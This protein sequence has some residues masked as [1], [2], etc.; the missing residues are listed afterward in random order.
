MRAVEVDVVA[1]ARK[2]AN[3]PVAVA[4]LP[5]I[6]LIERRV[7]A[8][9]VEPLAQRRTAAAGR[10]A[11]T[12]QVAEPSASSHVTSVR[13]FGGVGSTVG[14]HAQVP[15]S[16]TTS[17][18]LAGEQQRVARLQV[19]RGALQLGVR[20]AEARRERRRSV[21]AGDRVPLGPRLDL[22]DGLERLRL[23]AGAGDA[24]HAQA[25]L[26]RHDAASPAAPS[27]DPCVAA[28]GTSGGGSSAN[29][30]VVS[31][32]TPGRSR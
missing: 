4:G 19:E 25:R 11:S 31:A 32:A 12:S 13:S 29:A 15:V 23:L 22:L 21:E 3:G 5:E 24:L 17:M 1:A 7:V 14:E 2:S 10:P 20:V 8:E 28:A 16:G 18:S 26:E 30:S 9:D 27:P 6:R